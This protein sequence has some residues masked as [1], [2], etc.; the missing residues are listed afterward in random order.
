MEEL[1]NF[2]FFRVIYDF[3][4]SEIDEF[5]I[6]LLARTMAL[7]ST[8]AL[9]LLTLWILIRGYRIV[10]GQSH[11][12]MMG[13]VVDSLRATLILCF[14][15]GLALGGSTLYEF[16]GS[17]LPN[18]ISRVVT[19]SD[20]PV[21]EQIDRSMAVMQVALTSIDSLEVGHDPIV[22]KAK[23][24]DLWFT[25]IGT[26]GPALSGGAMLLMNQIA[27][28]LF[29][30]L[31]PIFV[32]S[33]LFEQTKSLFGRWLYYGIGTM[34][35][36]AVLSVMVTMA[37]D[38]VLAVAT[39]FWLSAPLAGNTEGITSLAMQQGGLGLILTVLILSAPPMAAA[40]FNGVLGNFSSF[41]AL[42][43]GGG[44]RSHSEPSGHAYLGDDPHLTVVGTR[45]V[46]AM[47]AEA[48]LDQIKRSAE[49]EPN[50]FL[51][52]Y[53]NALA[54]N[55]ALSGATPVNL[56][57]I[58]ARGMPGATYVDADGYIQGAGITKHE[59][60][61]LEKGTLTG[62]EAIVLHRTDSSTAE[63]ALTS[64]GRG[65][66]THFLVDKDGTIYQTASLSQK[67]A[68]IGKIKSRCY[69]EGA[70][71]AGEAA[72]IKKMGFSPTRIYH[73]EQVKAYPNRYPMNEDSVGIETVA[74]HLKSGWE[75][76][77]AAQSASIERLIGI[78]QDQYGLSDND[79]YEHD[80]ISYKTSGE[81]AGLFTSDDIDV[82]LVPIRLPPP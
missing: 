13:L 57:P 4:H 50:D 69:E 17:D 42:G 35:S 73:H 5:A 55:T 30:G 74:L 49:V 15:C 62:P 2:V 76:P 40:F 27:M 31:G 78:L 3:I 46:H 45:Y 47:P 6:D 41:S 53:P 18:E 72:T 1:S 60:A 54:S 58:V 20:T 77:T 29:I 48:S 67:T 82:P 34:F 25:G 63:G 14:A 52:R 39:A 56:W 32:L 26:A 71:S 9:S 79:V 70:C 36:L 33:L 66:G 38:M 22:N 10:T 61:A 75:A 44:R 28:A 81:G 51:V 68:H 23:S 24:R 80:K 64:F 8:A 37:L 43:G 59:V 7:V 21:I 65:I 19:G 12:P 11:Q 16:L